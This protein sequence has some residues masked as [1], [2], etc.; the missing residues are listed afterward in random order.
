MS[1]NPNRKPAG[2]FCASTC[3]S[4]PGLS[5]WQVTGSRDPHV[6]QSTHSRCGATTAHESPHRAQQAALNAV[7]CLCEPPLKAIEGTAS[8][9]PQWFQFVTE[10]LS[11]FTQRNRCRAKPAQ[12]HALTPTHSTPADG[13]LIIDFR[14]KH[15]LVVS[16]MHTQ[17]P[18]LRH[19]QRHGRVAVEEHE[20]NTPIRQTRTICRIGRFPR[21]GPSVL[22][23]TL[24]ANLEPPTHIATIKGRKIDVRLW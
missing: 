9:C 3:G 14:N 2:T 23:Y 22:I 1:G 8:L 24:P 7:A 5:L 20:T 18:T 6:H 13:G 19:V 11:S 16:S 4:M 15:G 10:R 17:Q 12:L 21:I